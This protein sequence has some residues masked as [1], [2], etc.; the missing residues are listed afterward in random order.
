MGRQGKVWF[1]GNRRTVCQPRKTTRMQAAQ[2]LRKL[3]VVV[4][5]RVLY[6]WIDIEDFLATRHFKAL[7]RGSL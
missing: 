2:W 7:L 5:F 3:E 1:V 4:I 6:V